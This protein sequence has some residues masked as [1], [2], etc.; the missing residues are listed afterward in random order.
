MKDIPKIFDPSSFE[1][2]RFAQEMNA[3]VFKPQGDGDSFCVMMPPPNVTGHLHMGHALNTTLQDILVRF[4]RMRGY[5]TLWQAGTDHAGIA[6]QALV[7]RQLE[8]Q[9]QDRYQLG[10]EEF[11]KAVWQWK[12]QSGNQILNQLQRLGASADWSRPRFTLDEGLSHAVRTAFVELYRK[13]LIYRGLRLVNW[14]PALMTAISDLEV[15]N[16]EVKGFLWHIRYPLIGGGFIVIATTRPE[17]MAG[18]SAIAVHPDDERYQNY[19]GR[20]CRLPLFDRTLP[21]IKD[22]YADMTKGSGAVKITPAHDFNDFHV[23]ERHHLPM[24]SIFDERACY[25]DKVPE[26]WQGMERFTARKQILEELEAQG[27]LEKTEEIVIATPHGDRSGAI[28]EPRLTHQWFVD[29]P[30]IAPVALQK[31]KQGDTQFVPSHWDK[32]YEQWLTDIQPWCIS[33]QIWWGHR[34]PAWY[35]ESGRIFVAMNEQE[36]EQM[37]REYHGKQIA[38]MQDNDVL[39]TWFSSAL[40]PFSTLG[41]QQKENDLA[42]YYPTSI[43]VTGFDII[44]FW[45][46]RMMMMALEL[47]GDVPFRKVYVHALV[48]DGK[49]QKMS[50]SKGNVIDPLE[51]IERYG[52]DSLRF[53]LASLTTPGRDV[54][55]DEVRLKGYRNFAT[56]LWNAARFCLMRDCTPMDKKLTPH[57]P[58]NKWML[59][60]WAVA[61]QEVTASL[62]EGRFDRACDRVLHLVRDSFCDWYLEMA[63][64]HIAKNDEE[65]R[66]TAGFMLDALLR[67]IHPFM[68]F[69]SGQLWCHLH[70]EEALLA[71]SA[72]HDAPPLTQD[73]DVTAI[74]LVMT[75]I[76][77]IRAMRAALNIAPKHLLSVNF[78]SNQETQKIVQDYEDAIR[79]MARI[80]EISFA[81]PLP[82]QL[83]FNFDN[84]KAGISPP[85]D[86]KQRAQH[87]EKNL[88]ALKKDMAQLMKKLDNPSFKARAP[89][90]VIAEQE[91]RL[92]DMKNEATSLEDILTTLR[93]LAKS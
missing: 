7:E 89:S 21:I 55:L 24:L 46:A 61:Q 52:A 20:E 1:Q 9:G 84:I 59:H 36:A 79:M 18:D 2:A 92:A 39:D 71:T 48:R 5:K 43:L 86:C 64:P 28:I 51:L 54:R 75:L 3:N 67:L 8:E 80:G 66:A 78:A 85:D 63:K 73:K 88:V 90:E 34:I 42:T 25:N 10:R 50:K 33:R 12:E 14:D 93:T 15:E 47:V 82:H 57:Q 26:R 62:E 16:R 53:T 37:A 49:G 83:T 29:T 58:L 74:A 27:L 69:V 35:D 6:T 31:V 60:Q 17:T 19:V 32:T 87:L 40:W 23:G 13:G 91:K 22:G 72:W 30:K 44:F 41:W 70:G 68:P 4:Y 81:E 45:V 76:G 65:T 56:K 38:L 11:L 77:K